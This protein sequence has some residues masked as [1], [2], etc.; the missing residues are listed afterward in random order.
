MTFVAGSPYTEFPE[1]VTNVFDV[2]PLANGNLTARAVPLLSCCKTDFN[3][4]PRSASAPTI[5]AYEY[6]SV[7]NPG[8]A[9]KIGKQSF[10]IPISI[11]YHL[12]LL[13]YSLFFSHNLVLYIS[14]ITYQLTLVMYLELRPYLYIP[15]VTTPPSSPPAATTLAP[16]NASC[17]NE[18]QSPFLNLY[19]SFE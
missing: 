2:Y 12:F 5:G 13:L 6:S 3:Q 14:I 4:N 11:F 8:W 15:P 19:C 7:S 10:K 16:V 9:P 18:T 1:T 17:A